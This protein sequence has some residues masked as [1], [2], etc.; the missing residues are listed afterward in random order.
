LDKY[1]FEEHCALV[2]DVIAHEPPK[3]ANSLL[4]DTRFKTLKWQTDCRSRFREKLFCHL[5]TI[6][7]GEA[8]RQLQKRGVNQMEENISFVVLEQGNQKLSRKEKECTF[9]ECQ[10]PQGKS[11]PRGATWRTR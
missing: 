6:C 2:N 9:W 8:Y 3:Y 7:K 1:N 4:K 5:E 10:D 11:S